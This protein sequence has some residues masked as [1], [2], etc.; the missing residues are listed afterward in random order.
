MKFWIAI[1]VP[2]G[3][4][5]GGLLWF[6]MVHLRDRCGR[7]SVTD[8]LAKVIPHDQDN[9]GLVISNAHLLRGQFF[10]FPYQC[11]ADSTPLRGGIDLTEQRWKHVEFEVS[12]L[13]GHIALRVLSP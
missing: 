5:V 3:L 11:E 6:G 12:Q 13:N 4:G 8:M 9:D 1:A 7:G 2:V 10:A